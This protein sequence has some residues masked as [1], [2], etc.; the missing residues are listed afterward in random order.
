IQSAH[1][2]LGG[3]QHVTFAADGKV[4]ISAGLVQPDKGAFSEVKAW[5]AASGKSLYML[6]PFKGAV[7][8]LVVSADGATFA[9]CAS[10]GSQSYIKLFEAAG[11]KDVT[12][13]TGP[14]KEIK[15]VAFAP[16][17]KIL[18]TSFNDSTVRLFDIGTGK[19]LLSFK[20]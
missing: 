13:I 17:E 9:A 14:K 3:V 19:E 10:E 7:R 1:R 16:E 18:A 6:T 20:G 5:D 8:G 11:G 2:G 4:L 12:T 15:A